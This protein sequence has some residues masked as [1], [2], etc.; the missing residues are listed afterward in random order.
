MPGA[1]PRLRDVT[2]ASTLD[3]LLSE[4]AESGRAWDLRLLQVTQEERP[5]PPAAVL[6]GDSIAL[7]FSDIHTQAG[8]AA[9]H[10]ARHGVRDGD[11]V[12]LVVPTGLSF[13][14]AFFACQRLAAVPVPVV[15]PWSERS[16]RTHIARLTAIAELCEPAATVI[17]P[18]LESR[19][20]AVA[21]ADALSSLLKKTIAG[22]DLLC[23]RDTRD[24][25]PVAADRPA[26]IQFTSGSTGRPKGVVLT[27][28]ALIANAHGIGLAIGVS[29]DDVACAWLPLFHD[30][31]LIGHLLGPLLWGVQSVLMP[32][33]VFMRSP[34]AWL[35][36]ISRYRAT[37][38]TAP[39]FAYELCQARTSERE[40]EALDLRCWRVA[41]CGGEPVLA[42][43]LERFAQRFAMG[44]RRH[45]RDDPFDL[46]RL[47]TVPSFECETSVE[48]A[49]RGATAGIGL[50]GDLGDSPFAAERAEDR[51]EIVAALE[52][53]EVP[54]TPFEHAGQPLDAAAGEV[55]GE[56]R[57]ACIEAHLHAEEGRSLDVG[58]HRPA[59]L[60]VA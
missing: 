10:L 17:A 22:D 51:I 31:G 43:T 45:V 9:A 2:R 27:H 5:H 55:A 41:M 26:M 52:Q 3:E 12:L 49:M 6:D 11:R 38:S 44:E 28:R 53:L 34:R 30:M 36:A 33:Q 8:R 13:V 20:H 40:V 46:F 39:N 23:E 19:L 16:L 15:P 35:R 47:E 60:R 24:T 42:A 50:V 1:K 29:S 37:V 56:Q 32:P 58:L 18:A 48:D 14:V 21:D 54:E 25:T 57:V 59:Q 7:S 4:R